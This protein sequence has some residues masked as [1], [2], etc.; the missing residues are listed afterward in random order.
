M[1][2]SKEPN[3]PVISSFWPNHTKEP[4]H[5]WDQWSDVIVAKENL[6]IDSFTG[7]KIPQTQILF[8]E[9][10]TESE[11]ELEKVSRETSNTNAMKIN[12]PAKEK[13]INE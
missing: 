9:Q 2:Q 5:F 3:L 7:P 13:R 6:N 8:L 12:K 1:E 4:P 10:A 11:Y